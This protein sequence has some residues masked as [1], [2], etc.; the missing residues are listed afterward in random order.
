MAGT[1]A[2]G[3]RRVVGLV[4]AALG[5]REQLTKAIGT[6]ISKEVGGRAA[7]HR[8]EVRE[9]AGTRRRRCALGYAT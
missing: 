3:G 1:A 8:Q 5:E 9:P 2:S 4:G 6:A 7:R